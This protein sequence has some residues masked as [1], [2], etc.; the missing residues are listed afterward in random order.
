MESLALLVAGL[1]CAVLLCGPAAY[2][3]AVLR[4]YI[5]AIIV[6]GMAIWLGVYW[7]ATVY[8]WAKYLGILSAG[9]GVLALL[10]VTDKLFYDH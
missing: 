2:T 7:F 3:L 5:L 6:A 10:K 9:L 4:F 8:T 1:F